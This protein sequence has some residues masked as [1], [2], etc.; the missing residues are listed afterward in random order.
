[1][2]LVESLREDRVQAA[3]GGTQG[4]GQAQMGQLERRAQGPWELIEFKGS[5]KRQRPCGFL[6][7]LRSSPKTFRVVSGL[8]RSELS[9]RGIEGLSNSRTFSLEAKGIYKSC[10]HK[11]TYFNS[12][13]MSFLGMK[14]SSR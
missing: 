8:E 1:M 12:F 5:P 14:M 13:L 3:R 10:S 4:L 9:G 2:A 11:L 6:C 7:F